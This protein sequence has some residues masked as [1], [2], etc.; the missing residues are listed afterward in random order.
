LKLFLTF[1]QSLADAKEGTISSIYG[2]FFLPFSG[3]RNGI[4]V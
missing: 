3:G 1:A 2:P 4:A